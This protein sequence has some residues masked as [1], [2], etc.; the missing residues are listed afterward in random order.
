MNS[1]IILKSKNTVALLACYF[2]KLPW[3]F[4]YFAHS[5]RHNADVDFFFISDD[6]SCSKKLPANVK[7]INYTLDELRA[8]ASK[9]LGLELSIKYGYKLCD[10]K[11]AY[12]VIFSDIIAGYD[13]W[14]HTDIDIIFGSIREFMTDQLLEE[15][16]LISVR[17][18][19]LTGCFMLYRNIDKVNY[20]FTY[21]KD[22]KKVFCSD[23]HYCFDETNF[24]HNAFTEG[25]SYLEIS[26][27]IESMTHVV[28]RM[29]AAGD[30]KPFF[31]LYIIEGLPGKLKWEYGKMYYRNVYEVMLYHMIHF[32]KLYVPKTAN[33]SMLDSF[34]ISPTTIYHKQ[35]KRPA[36]GI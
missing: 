7:L 25:G 32:K 24:A 13:F 19:W 31:D 22:Y 21:S 17:P 20:L 26:T 16:D 33:F 36:H 11:P 8:I 15:Y 2:G 30:I 4:D 9:K 10:F 27:E 18:D 23:K 6:T 14:G 5:C 34:H 3:Y 1:K 29:E 12:G 28:K 35:Y